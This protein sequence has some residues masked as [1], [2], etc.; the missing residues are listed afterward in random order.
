MELP[1]KFHFDNANVSQPCLSIVLDSG[2]V[3][4][5]TTIYIS[6]NAFPWYQIVKSN[7]KTW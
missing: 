6:W 3:P 4:P 5:I 7:Y 2:D 1:K